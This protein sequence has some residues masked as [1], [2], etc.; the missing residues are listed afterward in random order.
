MLVLLG[1]KLVKLVQKII[2]FEVS[3]KNFCARSCI[4][5]LAENCLKARLACFCLENVVRVN[6]VQ[7]CSDFPAK[8]L[9]IFFKKKFLMKVKD[10]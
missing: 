4:K 5:V 3:L 2:F 8:R 9:S 6:A 7:I 10:N 1:F